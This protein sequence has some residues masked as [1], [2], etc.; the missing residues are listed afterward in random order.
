MKVALISTTWTPLNDIPI[1]YLFLLRSH[2]CIHKK[3]MRLSVSLRLLT[4]YGACES[5]TF[6][7]FWE[8]AIILF[9]WFD[10]RETLSI[11]NSLRGFCVDRTN[12]TRFNSVLHSQQSAVSP[13]WRCMWFIRHNIFFKHQDQF[14]GKISSKTALL[15]TENQK[16]SPKFIW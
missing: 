14:W 12:V 2:G 3:S 15:S 9:L 1:S 11:Q 5:F 6:W 8:E 4:V 10:R 16:L 7:N 13:I